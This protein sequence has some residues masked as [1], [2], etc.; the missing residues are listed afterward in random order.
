[1]RQAASV[2]QTLADCRWTDIQR[3]SSKQKTAMQL[4]GITGRIA[5]RG[6]DLTS[7]LPLFKYCETTHLGKQT[8]FG[9]GRIRVETPA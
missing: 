2:E 4:G 1:V 5:Y 6:D 9:L 7:F 8:T 3:Y